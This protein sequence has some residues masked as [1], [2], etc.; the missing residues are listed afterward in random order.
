MKKELY[1]IEWQCFELGTSGT[2]IVSAFT[3]YE[4]EQYFYDNYNDGYEL[5]YIGKAND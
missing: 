3:Q 5:V 4:A 1:R 2:D